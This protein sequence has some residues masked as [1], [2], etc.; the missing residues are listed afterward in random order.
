[1]AESRDTAWPD[2]VQP[3]GCLPKLTALSET[4][5]ETPET[6]VALLITQRS[7]VQI[8]PPPPESAG[9]KPDRQEAVRLLDRLSAVRPRDLACEHGQ[10]DLQVLWP[11]SRVG[12]DIP[13]P[14]GRSERATSGQRRLKTAA[15]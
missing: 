6:R 10:A 14:A 2:Q 3:T 12:A 13:R 7:R 5:R 1:P 4:R 9:R 15:R 8:P 11:T